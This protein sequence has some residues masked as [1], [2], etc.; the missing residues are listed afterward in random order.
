[1]IEQWAGGRKRNLWTDPV[2]LVE[3]FPIIAHKRGENVF[4]RN[5]GPLHRSDKGGGTG[6]A[7]M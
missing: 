4:G 1:M 7:S 3:G 2:L 6:I 5:T